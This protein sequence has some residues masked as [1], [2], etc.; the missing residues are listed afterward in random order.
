MVHSLRTLPRAKKNWDQKSWSE[1]SRT[2]KQS[3]V[4]AGKR[5][6]HTVH[7]LL[8]FFYVIIVSVSTFLMLKLVPQ[9]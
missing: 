4:V 6:E 2:L 5:S 8:E 1:R 3:T 9:T 7:A